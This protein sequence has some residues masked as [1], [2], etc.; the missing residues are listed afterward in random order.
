MSASPLTLPAQPSVTTPVVSPLHD[1]LRA[2]LYGGDT[3]ALAE[4]VDRAPVDRRDA[5]LTLALIHDLHIG[6][7][8]DVG[9]AARFQH[10]PVV[11]VLKDRIEAD[12]QR[13]LH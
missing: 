1:D 3:A 11:A 2:A 10:H 12:L 5:A 6:P 4:L 9:D 7:I 8:M 13:R